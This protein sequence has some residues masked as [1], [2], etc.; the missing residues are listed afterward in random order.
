LLAGNSFGFEIFSGIAKAIYSIKPRF[1]DFANAHAYKFIR[2][3]HGKRGENPPLPRNCNRRE[4]S[5]VATEVVPPGKAAQS[6]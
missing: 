3:M 1:L 4:L 6:L 5:V 2:L